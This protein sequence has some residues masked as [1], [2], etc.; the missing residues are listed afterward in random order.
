MHGGSLLPNEIPHPSLLRQNSSWCA[1]HRSVGHMVWN[2]K[3]LNPGGAGAQTVNLYTFTC[4]AELKAIYG[5]FTDVTNVVTVSACSWDVYDGTNTVPLTAAAGTNCSGAALYSTV[6]KDLVAASALTFLNSTQVRVNEVS[7]ANR[8]FQSA[9]LLAKNGVTNYLRWKYTS[10][11]NTN[12]K[13]NFCA[14]WVC[15]YPG[16]T[17][18]AV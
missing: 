4:E 2:E 12:C 14:I 1:L 17:V 18:V 3:T 8:Q 6:I 13:V 15:R 7:G 16:T 10:D 5:V 11:V 9:I